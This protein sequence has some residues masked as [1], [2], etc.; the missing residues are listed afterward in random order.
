MLPSKHALPTQYSSGKIQSPL[1]NQPC[2]AYCSGLALPWSEAYRLFNLSCSVDMWSSRALCFAS[3]VSC[4]TSRRQ[5]H[6]W[7]HWAHLW[8]EHSVTQAGLKHRLRMQF[9]EFIDSDVKKC[10]YSVFQ[11]REDIQSLYIQNPS[12]WADRFHSIFRLDSETV[13]FLQLSCINPKREWWHL[14]RWTDLQNRD[15]YLPLTVKRSSIG[16]KQKTDILSPQKCPN[17]R[18]QAPIYFT[19]RLKSHNIN[20]ETNTRI[21]QRRGFILNCIRRWLK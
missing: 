11:K 7:V 19:T 17:Y 10:I 2:S 4:W 21:S 20:M 15:E 6:S 5:E 12:W 9:S 8:L 13:F 1:K 18:G 3:W 14:H 16:C